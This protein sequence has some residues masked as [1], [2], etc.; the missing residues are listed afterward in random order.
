MAAS[1]IYR[2]KEQRYYFVGKAKERE[3]DHTRTSDEMMEY[4]CEKIDS[5]IINPIPLRIQIG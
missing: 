4:Y 3:K 2:A 5:W 1:E